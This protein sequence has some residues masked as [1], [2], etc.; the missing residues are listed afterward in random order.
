MKN[1]WELLTGDDGGG[2]LLRVGDS[3]ERTAKGRNGE[4][5]SPRVSIRRGEDDI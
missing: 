3:K 1:Y 2:R 4:T 5:F